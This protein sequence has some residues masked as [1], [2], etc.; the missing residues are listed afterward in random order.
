ML[1]H[2]WDESTWAEQ[3]PPTARGA[4]PGRRR[5]AGLPVPGVASTP[6]SCSTALLAACPAAATRPGT[7]RPAGCAATPTTWS[8]ASRWARSP[9]PSAARAQRAALRTAASLG[10]AAVHECGGPGTSSE[11]DFTDVL[12]LGRRAERCPRCTAT[13]ASCG[14]GE[15]AR[16]RRRRRRRRP[17]RRRRARR[18][19]PRTCASRT[20]TPRDRRP[21]ATGTS[22]PSRSASTWSTAR[23][24]GVQGGFHAIGDAG[25]SHGVAGFAVGRRRRVGRRP[26]AGGAAPHRARRDRRQARSI[27]GLVELRRRGEHAAGVRP[28]VGRRR[29]RCTRSAWA[30]PRSLASNPFGAM[31]GV[32]VALAFGSDSPVTPLDPWGTVRAAM[33]HHNPAQRHERPGRVRRAHPRRLAGGAPRRRGRARARA[34]RPRSRSG[35]TPARP[36]GGL[37]ALVAAVGRR[38]RPGRC[39]SAART[40]LRGSDRSTTRRSA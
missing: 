21:A 4:R 12:A 19:R 33:R 7:T 22:P 26:A 37:P 29:R 34:R 14:R 9:R 6:R 23:G 35:T 3:T 16:A 38:A 2:G 15:G 27:A 32:G 40:V 11:T 39:R 36:T 18:R 25:A 30:W 8:A 28:A 5:P 17:V 20:W 1:G 31:H 10:I 24:T 13:G